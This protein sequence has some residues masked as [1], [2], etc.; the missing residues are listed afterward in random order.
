M[1]ADEVLV[2]FDLFFLPLVQLEPPAVLRRP[3]FARG[4]VTD[5][6]D[7]DL[8]ERYLP[9]LVRYPVEEVAVVRDENEPA[10][11]GEEPLFE[12]VEGGEIEV[13][14]RL[15]EEEEVRLLREDGCE[16]RARLLPAG[17][18]GHLPG[19]GILGEP[20]AGE[21]RTDPRLDRVPPLRGE[22]V[23]EVVVAAEGLLI[24]GVCD[25]LLEAPGLSIASLRVPSPRSRAAW[26]R[27]PTHT[28]PIVLTSPSVGRSSPAMIERRVDFPTPL[29]PTRAILSPLEQGLRPERFRYPFQLNE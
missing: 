26:E 19:E 15:V 9:R 11:E 3:E 25:P 17:E 22:P 14:R 12:P 18:G 4:G 6:I 20:D 2:P 28:F 16:G 13:V 23:E 8:S 10:R 7:R 5:G 29:S 27:W 1:T 24:G 21:R